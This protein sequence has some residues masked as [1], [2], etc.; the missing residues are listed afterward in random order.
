MNEDIYMDFILENYKNPKNYGKIENPTSKSHGSN[1]L[2]GDE[3]F[4]YLKIEENKISDIK[5]MGR[6]CAISQASASILTEMV[7]GKDLDYAKNLKDEDL[8]KELGIKLSPVRLKCA[9]L[10]L[11]TLREAISNIH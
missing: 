4:I 6:G 10:S 9:L 7:K 3:I 11:L 1:P 8:L 5:F 2:C